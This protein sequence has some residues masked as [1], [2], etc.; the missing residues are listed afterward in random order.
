MTNA[1]I[2]RTA[3]APAAIALLQVPALSALLDRALPPV[4]QARFCCLINHDGSIV[5]EVVVTRLSDEQMEIACHGGPGMRAAVEAACVSHGLKAASLAPASNSDMSQMSNRDEMDLWQALARACCPAAVEWFMVHGLTAPPFPAEF[6]YRLPTILITGPANAGKS[7]LLNAWCG[8][9]RALVSDIPGTTRDLLA[10]QTLVFGWRLALIDSAGLRTG[11]DEIEQA[12][13]ALVATARKTADVVLY[14]QP[15]GENG[16]EKSVKNGD[17]VIAGKADLHPNHHGLCW[18]SRGI[19]GAS[20]ELLLETL[21]LAVLAH[22]R[23]P[24]MRQ[25]AS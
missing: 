6:L 17:L 20:A 12:G 19:P 22:L 4:G 1:W 3:S 24:P 25:V 2:W 10:G 5:D 13:Q 11:G 18:S 15:P 21:G 16:D 8:H 23:L 7:T 9:Q 14:L